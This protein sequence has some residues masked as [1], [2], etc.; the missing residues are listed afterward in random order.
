MRT[1]NYKNKNLIIICWNFLCRKYT[2]LL[3]KHALY[4]TKRYVTENILL[5]QPFHRLHIWWLSRQD[6][7]LPFPQYFLWQLRESLYKSSHLLF[8]HMVTTHIGTKVEVYNTVFGF[9]KELL[10]VLKIHYP[11][12]FYVYSV[13]ETVTCWCVSL[14]LTRMKVFMDIS[15]IYECVFLHVHTHTHTHTHIHN[16]YNVVICKPV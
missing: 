10:K 3:Y 16:W 7:R 14:L 13:S 4:I 11:N 15:D 2:Y 1:S 9:I 5:R 6:V 12:C 8:W